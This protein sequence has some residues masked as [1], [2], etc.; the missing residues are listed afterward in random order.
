[1]SSQTFQAVNPVDGQPFG[2]E[3]SEGTHGEVTAAISALSAS[4]TAFA[5]LSLSDRANLLEKIASELDSA[6]ADLVKIAELETGIPQARLNGEVT[7]TMIQLQL[8]AAQ[9]RKGAHLNAVID[10]ADADYK[11]APRPDMRKMNL[12]IG[13]VA[14]FGASNFPFAFS[15]IGGDSASALAAGCPVIVKAHPSHP[16]VSELTFQA[17]QRALKS[18]GISGDVFAIVQG[19]NPEITHWL[20]LA[21]EICAVGFTGSAGV[22]KLLVKLC[23]SRQIPIPVYA[24]MGSLNPVFVTA[25][26]MTERGVSIAEMLFDSAVLGAGQFC[27]KPGLIFIGADHEPFVATIRSK[28]ESVGSQPLLNKGILDRYVESVKSLN[29]IEGVESITGSVSVEGFIAQPTFFVMDY[30][31]FKTHPEFAEEHFGPTTVIVKCSEEDFEEIIAQ[32]QGQLTATLHIGAAEPKAALLQKLA[33]I[34]GRVI[35]N[36]APT[37]VSVTAAQS[38]GGPWPSSSTHTTSVG[39]DAVFRFMRPVTFQ[40]FADDLLPPALQQANPEKIERVV[41]GVR[42]I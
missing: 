29:Q 26:A 16:G 21:E 32:S 12:P 37:G 15:T 22:G 36:G 2:K 17:V 11:P 20:A 14:V 27:T 6:R 40:G 23:N 25:A 30:A 42:R 1:M 24:E 10:L 7:R 28:M 3:Y 4:A 18:C 5:A 13:P 8:F 34:A 9:V 35:L 33:T 41:N 19:R 31:H 38:H 39:T